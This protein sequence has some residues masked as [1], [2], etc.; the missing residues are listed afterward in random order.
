MD[1][2]ESRAEPERIAGRTEQ[3]GSKMGLPSYGGFLFGIPFVAAGTGVALIGMRVIRVNP[4]SVHAPYW[5][6]TAFGIVFV[7]GGL[8]VWSMAWRQFRENRRRQEIR[9][10]GVHEKIL[11][12][13]DWQTRGFAVPR[14]SKF[15]KSLLTALFLTLFFSIFNFLAFGADGPWLV[16][17]VV[18]VFDL[19]TAAVW[20][21]TSVILGRTLKFGGSRLDFTDFPYRMDRP[22]TLRWY[23]ANGIDRARKGQFT[24]RCVK[25]W[26][27]SHGHGK[28]HSTH[29]VHEQIWCGI[30]RLDNP[31]VFQPGMPI[32]I[33]YEPPA[34]L[35]STQ[36]S[37]DKPVF[38][39]M[40]IQLDLPGL[41]FE[42][43]YLVPIYQTD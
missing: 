22:V 7:L 13:Y 19:I 29:L 16:K 18:I 42:E 17:C 39:E 10:G 8:A 1:R 38:W 36:L 43:V 24:L 4:N 34:D 23:P 14:W 9:R 2:Y 33:S 26:Y 28:H 35:P 25:E 12:D 20:W 30:W 27:E 5:V 41:D 37:A 11:S 32:E 3:R 21:E 40:D 15:V 31:K 6:L